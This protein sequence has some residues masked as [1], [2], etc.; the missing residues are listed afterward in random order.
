MPRRALLILACVCNCLAPVASLPA[1]DP[2]VARPNIVLI[3]AD[4]LGYGDLGCYGQKKI[5]TP[6]LDQMAKEGLR[7]TQFY[8]GSPVCAPSRCVLM[9]GKHSGHAAIRDNRERRPE[10]QFPLPAGEVTIAEALKTQGYDTAAIGKWGLGPYDAD[11]KLGE[12]SPLKQG[13][14][15]FF[16][17]ICQ[18]YAHNHY[19]GW[20]WKN[21]EK[22]I[23]KDE[24]A[25]KKYGKPGTNGFN[26]FEEFGVT[27]AGDLFEEEAIKFLRD[28]KE[29]P[30]FLYLP[31]TVPHLALQV[32]DDSL[33][34][35]ED[36]WDDPAYDGK[37]GYLPHDSPRAAYAA[38][39]SRLDRSVGRI[40]DE[41]KTLGLDEKTLVVF[42]SDNGPAPLNT[43]GADSPFFESAG[44]LR[45]LKG[46][47]Y[48]GGIRVPCIARWPGK[49]TAEKESTVPLAFYDLLPTLCELSGATP[50]AD[51]DGLSFV[52]TLLGKGEQKQH[53]LLYWEFAGYTGY[54]AVRF[55]QWKA[56]RPRLKKG[57][58]TIDLYNLAEDLGE[59]K[60]LAADHPEI[61]KKAAEL[62]AAEHVKNETFPLPAIDMD[63]KDS[64]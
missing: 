51:I 62:M 57:D 45:G 12:G 61:V 9:T 36:K 40:L 49:I 63:V 10:G 17:Y 34:E 13:F 27:Y 1:A 30:F 43:G 7:F 53:E 15:S 59:K 25:T 48:E 38:M 19:P 32:P 22:L 56:I 31:F 11:P 28:H 24:E 52:P 55:E 50:P 5:S 18:R 44:P 8:A 37:Q 33:R 26:A 4:D 54:Q 46:S 60:D 2:A 14:D 47:A 42:T 20:L 35:Y 58:T 41:I 39:V 16:G 3:M 6:R 64:M 23:L 29:K 21:Q